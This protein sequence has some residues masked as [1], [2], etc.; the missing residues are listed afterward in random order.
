MWRGE[1]VH[2]WVHE[3]GFCIF[4]SRLV[5]SLLSSVMHTVC[6]CLSTEPPSFLIESVLSF[7][8]LLSE[9]FIERLNASQRAIHHCLY[10]LP[11]PVHLLEK[12]QLL[13][14]LFL[15]SPF[16]LWLF[17]SVHLISSFLSS[18]FIFSSPRFFNSSPLFS[19]FF[20]SCFPLPSFRYV[21]SLL[22]FMSS[23]FLSL[24]P[25]LSSPLISSGFISCFLSS[26]P[27]SLFSHFLFFFFPFCSSALFS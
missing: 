19:S 17:F 18:L 12:D 26:P 4:K 24:F 22:V 7:H 21:S 13:Y 15:P 20:S 6:R 3:C 9:E 23:H 27:C 1:R 2:I 16:P 14:F 11:L 8:L 10:T 25:L 5:P